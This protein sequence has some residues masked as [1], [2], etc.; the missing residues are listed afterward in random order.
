MTQAEVE[1]HQRL[2]AQVEGMRKERLAWWSHWRDLA[3]YILPRRYVWLLTE[4]EARIPKQRN[5]YILDSTGTMAARTLAS[6]MMNG[7]TSPA[8]PWFRLRIPGF[9]EE[10][11]PSRMWLDVCQQRMRL[12]MAESNF[13]QA[14]A[15]LYLDLSVFGTPAM[16]IYEDFNDI[17]RCYNHALGEFYAEHDNR[18]QVTR[19]AR[20]FVWKVHQVVTEYGEA[21][22]STRVREAHRAGG[23]RL[24]ESVK[25]VHLIEPNTD[26]ALPGNFAFREYYWED[27]APEKGKYLRIAGFREFP[28]VVPRWELTAN[29]SYGSSPGMDALPDIIQL[30]HETKKKAQALDKLVDPPVIA[31]IQLSNQPTSLL[32]RGI[33][34]VAGVNNVGVKPIHTIDGLPLAELTND[35]TVLQSR[36]RQTFHNDLFRMIAELDTV[37]SATEIDARREEK[38]VLLGPVLDRF[39]TEALDPAITRIFKIMERKELLPPAPEELVGGDIEIQYVSVLSDAQRAV[40]TIP[41]ERFAQF[42]GNLGAIQP[43]VLD[44][45][46]WEEMTREYGTALG[47]PAKV[48]NSRESTAEKRKAREELLSAQQSANVGDVLTK[49]AK[50]LSETQ[51]GGGANALQALMGT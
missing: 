44:V 29:D 39:E 31:D 27:A 13:Y 49:S 23:A 16:S 30:Q 26:R 8:R 47:I 22:C 15:I 6:G 33:T 36:I 43:E 17:F 35:I 10:S 24:Y 11:S 40:A 1:R 46:N 51:V 14:M 41:I 32:P 12:A 18:L 2:I 28:T 21:N 19:F 4:A 48:M 42:T 3:D 9:D 5:Q 20:E 34:Y 37:R 45:P 7:I 50:Q 38:L 25:L